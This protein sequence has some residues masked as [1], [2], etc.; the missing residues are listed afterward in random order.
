M[1]TMIDRLSEVLSKRGYEIDPDMFHYTPEERPNSY[2]ALSV[3][4]LEAMMEPTESMLDAAR[5][6]IMWTEFSRP[7][8]AALIAHC[9]RT[10]KQPP[11]YCRDVDHVPPKALRTYWIHRAIISDA[12]REEGQ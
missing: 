4:V 2:K 10:G 6:L 5:H 8:E 3:A 7:T 12:L 1:T 11:E 9:R